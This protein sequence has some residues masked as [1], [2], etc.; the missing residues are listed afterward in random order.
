L[1]DYLLDYDLKWMFLH[2]DAMTVF[3]G[4]ALREELLA[5]LSFI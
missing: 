5:R 2:S 4:E 1:F 3:F